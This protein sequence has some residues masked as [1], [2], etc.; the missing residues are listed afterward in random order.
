[1]SSTLPNYPVPFI[2]NVVLSSSIFFGWPHR[3]LIYDS[4][5]LLNTHHPRPLLTGLE[6]LPDGASV[7][8]AN[9]Y[10]RPGLWI[11]WIGAMLAVG[12]HSRNHVDPPLRMISTDEQRFRWRGQ[13]RTVPFSRWFLRRVARFWGMIPM[14]ADDADTSGRGGA[15]RQALRYLQQGQSI[16]IFPEGEVGTAFQ[17]T[18]ALPGTGTFLGLA[19]RYAPI[20]PVRFWEDG[21]QLR[22]HIGSPLSFSSR[23]DAGLRAEAMTAIQSV[24]P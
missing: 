21:D 16:L 15:L 24:R 6:H 1:M 12:L 14:P 2:A 4:T 22:G 10:Q 9:H 3:S 19:T 8:I 5:F 18:D 20:L 13:W 7:L 17:M 11:G 23:D